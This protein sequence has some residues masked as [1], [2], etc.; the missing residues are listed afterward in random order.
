MFFSETDVRNYFLRAAKILCLKGT[1]VPGI[2][3]FVYITCR[4]FRNSVKQF[5]CRADKRKKRTDGMTDTRTERLPDLNVL[6]GRLTNGSKAYPSNN[7]IPRRSY[8]S[9]K[10]GQLSF[11]FLYEILYNYGRY[12]CK[13]ISDRNKSNTALI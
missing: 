11:I 9:F 6:S 1:K 10:G 3:H 7:F 8:F 13:L 4:F 5:K 12:E 2:T